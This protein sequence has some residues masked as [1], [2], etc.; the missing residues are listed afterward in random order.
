ML[1][2]IVNSI[3]DMMVN[4]VNVTLVCEDIKFFT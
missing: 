4:F 1:Q 3:N 2:K